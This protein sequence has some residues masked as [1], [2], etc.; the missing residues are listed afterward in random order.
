[1][2]LVM[3][4]IPFSSDLSRPSSVFPSVFLS[5]QRKEPRFEIG[6]KVSGERES[7]RKREPEIEMCGE[8]SGVLWCCH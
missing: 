6:A 4:E 7:E 3:R 2:T 1:M 8:W 5:E